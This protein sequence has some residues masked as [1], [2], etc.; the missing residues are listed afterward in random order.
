MVIKPSKASASS[1]KKQEK[2]ERVVEPIEKEDDIVLNLRPKDLD[3]YVG[4]EVLKKH[5]AV[6]IESAKIRKEPLEH[7]L[8][9]GP[10]GL[11]KTTISNIIALE[12]GANIK[13]SSGPAI[14][15]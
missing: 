4:Q 1:R 12:M 2:V 11:W 9:Y 15:L 13:T 10:P 7:I 3:S 8:F 5:L 14:Y 6:S